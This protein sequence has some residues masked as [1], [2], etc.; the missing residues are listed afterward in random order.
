MDGGDVRENTASTERK[1]ARPKEDRAHAALA[2]W[3][4]LWRD[5]VAS[6]KTAD[7]PRG[8][9][10]SAG[11]KAAPVDGW[12]RGADDS[13]G[14]WP[15][16]CLLSRVMQCHTTK[17]VRVHLLGRLQMLRPTAGPFVTAAEKEIAAAAAAI[18]Q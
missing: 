10:S 5:C 14:R 13:A 11:P 4:R 1:P 2:R 15:A 8:K 7:A 17:A 6:R 12:P 16:A 18:F 9:A 3:R